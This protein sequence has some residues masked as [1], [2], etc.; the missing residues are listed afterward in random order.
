MQSS[1][2]PPRGVTCFEHLTNLADS[3]IQ[4]ALAFRE[5]H[6]LV[7]IAR[8]AVTTRDGLTV[9]EASTDLETMWN[10]VGGPGTEA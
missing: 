10:R 9:E 1:P 5:S 7:S 3:A 8:D 2:T 6:E 4:H